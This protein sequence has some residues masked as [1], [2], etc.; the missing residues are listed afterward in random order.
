MTIGRMRIACCITEATD[1]HS[2][3]VNIYC[4]STTTMVTRTHP[5]LTLYVHCL[6]CFWLIFCYNNYQSAVCKVGP[7]Q[8]ALQVGNAV[9]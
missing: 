8:I 2:E 5:N 6:S 3:G 7:R 4:F 1:R 9:V